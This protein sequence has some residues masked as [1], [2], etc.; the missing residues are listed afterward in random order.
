VYQNAGNATIKGAEL[1]MQAALG[2]GFALNLAAGW[3]DAYY[4]SLNPCLIYNETPPQSG[5]CVAANGLSVTMA[6]AGLSAT[7]PRLRVQVLGELT[8]DIICERQ[9]PA[10]AGGL[11]CHRAHVQRRFNTSLYRPATHVLNAAVHS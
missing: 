3:M 1:E 4:T 2:G 9:Y 5:N 8:W 10:L 7:C 11:H 6:V